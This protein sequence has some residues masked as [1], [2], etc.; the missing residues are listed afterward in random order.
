MFLQK[1]NIGRKETVVVNKWLEWKELN[2][3]LYTPPPQG[4][5]FNL[6]LFLASSPHKRALRKKKNLETTLKCNSEQRLP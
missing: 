5:S 3:S 4:L 1:Y 2:Q 6:K